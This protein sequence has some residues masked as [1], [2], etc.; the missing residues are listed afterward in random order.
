MTVLLWKNEPSSTARLIAGEILIDD[1]PG[2][3]VHVSHF[4]VTHLLVG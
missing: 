4:G 2:A 1:T 3:E